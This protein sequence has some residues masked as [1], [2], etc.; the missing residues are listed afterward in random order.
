MKTLKRF[1]REMYKYKPDQTVLRLNDLIDVVNNLGVSIEQSSQIVG[2]QEVLVYGNQ[3]D[4]TF[5]IARWTK[6]G[7]QYLNKATVI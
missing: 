4:G 3:P 2:S 1:D 6:Q 5:G 7:D